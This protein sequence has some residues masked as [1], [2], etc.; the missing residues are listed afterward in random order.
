MKVSATNI[1]TGETVTKD[2]N[3][4]DIKRMRKILEGATPGSDEK[5]RARLDNLDLPGEVKAALAS[6]TDWVIKIGRR[7]YKIGRRLLDLFISLVSRYPS[8][9]TAMLLGIFC[10][11]V[12]SHVPFVGDLLGMAITGVL[13]LIGFMRDWSGSMRQDSALERELRDLM[14]IKV[15]K[16]TA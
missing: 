3:E 12:L 7:T 10:W 9:T 5:L 14:G 16:V 6:W 2:A 15:S 13:M 8:M 11:F 1:K 4:A